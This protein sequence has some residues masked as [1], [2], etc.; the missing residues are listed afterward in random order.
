MSRL[1]IISANMAL[2][3]GD[4]Q[5]RYLGFND[6]ILARDEKP[7]IVAL[8]EVA[9]HPG[10]ASLTALQLELGPEYSIEFCPIYPG[11]ENEKGLVMISRYPVLE[12]KKVDLSVGGKAIQLATIELP[13]ERDLQ[14]ANVHMEASPLKE[15][16]RKKK[17][18]EIVDVLAQNPDL[19]HMIVGDFNAERYFPSVRAVK[20]LGMDSI[21][22]TLRTGD[23]HT[24]PTSIGPKEI[25]GH[26]YS[27]RHQYEFM[28]AL[29]QFMPGGSFSKSG[30][31]ESVVDYIFH[32]KHIQ[33]ESAQ[34]L[35]DM[36]DGQHLS[37]HKFIEAIMT[38]V[39]A[40]DYDMADLDGL[41][42]LDTTAQPESV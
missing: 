18:K 40:S 21:F 35:S 12:H 1:E 20:K 39:D 27:K 17:T 42:E 4:A 34:V 6:L 26:G 2:D 24:Y 38:L 23:E 36:H 16:M 9:W 30:L 5:R 3:N 11:S 32:N 15:G 7:D 41:S 28:K 10:E 22:N 37:D 13:T 14:I 31:R 29:G 19:A 25:V 8:Q 33:P